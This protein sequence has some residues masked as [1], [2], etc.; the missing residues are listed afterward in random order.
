VGKYGEGTGKKIE[1]GWGESYRLETDA[2]RMKVLLPFSEEPQCER[3]TEKGRK[4]AAFQR[5]TA[6]TLVEGDRTF[7]WGW[8]KSAR[9]CLG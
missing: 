9:E 5:K 4:K 6:Q 1:E 3:T 7:R 8:E 2:R